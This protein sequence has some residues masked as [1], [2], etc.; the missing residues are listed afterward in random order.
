MLRSRRPL[1]GDRRPASARRDDRPGTPAGGRHA[2]PIGRHVSGEQRGVDHC[3][4]RERARLDRRT[5]A[6]RI[7]RAA[8][9]GGARAARG[10]R[11]RRQPDARPRHG[12][13]ARAGAARRDRRG[14]GARRAPAADREPAARA[15]RRRARRPGGVVGSAHT[16]RTERPVPAAGR[17]HPSGRG[18]ARLRGAHLAADG[19]AVRRVAGAASVRRFRYV[20]HAAR[21]F[22]RKR[23]KRRSQSRARR[24]GHDGSSPRR[25]A[26]G[27]RGSDAAQL[28]AAHGG[29]SGVPSRERAARPHVDAV[30]SRRR[31]GQAGRRSTAGGRPR[32]GRTGCGVGRRDQ[33]R[34][35]HGKSRRAPSI[36]GAWPADARSG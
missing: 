16:G 9:R 30:L 34:A 13:G 19:R 24:A 8:R 2:D 14:T 26:R 18:R 27:W 21:G 35:A 5:G 10:V 15:V 31:A 29:R 23:G 22:A 11:E 36:R 6:A 4:G 33:E 7:A 32:A 1:A 20:D 3:G 25:G 12:A 17:R 28:R